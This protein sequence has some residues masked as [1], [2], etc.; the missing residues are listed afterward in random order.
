MIDIEVLSRKYSLQT[1]SEIWSAFVALAS[2]TELKKVHGDFDVDRTKVSEE[3]VDAA[4]RLRKR[5][6]RLSGTVSVA[7]EVIADLSIVGMHVSSVRVESEA[8]DQS[9]CAWDDGDGCSVVVPDGE[10]A[11]LITLLLDLGVDPGD[12]SKTEVAAG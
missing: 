7:D 12:I 5:Q 9:L 4:R 10:V 8:S 11:K 3:I 1:R 2:L 6:G